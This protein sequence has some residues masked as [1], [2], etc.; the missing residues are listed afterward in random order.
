VDDSDEAR[1]VHAE[2][3]R[4]EARID[5]LAESLAGIVAASESANLDDE[6]DPEGATVGFERAQVSTL[7]ADARARLA[8]LDAALVRLHDGDYGVCER[9]GQPIAAARLDAQPATRVCIACA[10]ARRA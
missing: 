1:H 6:H 10:S 5:E 4:V 9:C 2:R 3:V 8:E 7:L